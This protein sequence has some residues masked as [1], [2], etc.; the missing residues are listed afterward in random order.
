MGKNGSVGL[1]KS[2]FS[3]YMPKGL[4]WYRSEKQVCE[5]SGNTKKMA[6]VCEKWSETFFAL[7]VGRFSV[8]NQLPGAWVFLQKAKSLNS[9]LHCYGGTTIDTSVQVSRGPSP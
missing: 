2:M 8:G 3:D 6:V 1:K 5:H 4:W 9:N 7:L